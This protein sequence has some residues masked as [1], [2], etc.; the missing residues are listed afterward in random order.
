MI[1]SKGKLSLLS[2]LLFWTS[3]LWAQ[4]HRIE[5]EIQGLANDTLIL[6]EYFT[7]RMV[8]KDTLLLDHNG[9]G[10]FEGKEAL[11]G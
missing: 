10:V 11:S 7:S 3:L 9:M 5:V 2:I 4:G 8:P 6:G 1:L